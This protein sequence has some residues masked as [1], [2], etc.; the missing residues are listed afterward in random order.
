MQTLSLIL[1]FVFVLAGSTLAG[2]SDGNLPG[3]GAF[4]YNGSAYNGSPIMSDA[5]QAIAVAAR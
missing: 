3:I 5:P 1:A 2:S 4:A